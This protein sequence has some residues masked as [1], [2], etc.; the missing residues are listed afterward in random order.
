MEALSGLTR[1]ERDVVSLVC[2]GHANK[3]IARKLS[4]SDGTVKQH[5]HAVYQ[6]LGVRGR[7]RLIAVISSEMSSRSP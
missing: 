6:K 1:R 5:V 4:I 3:E 7:A 2:Q